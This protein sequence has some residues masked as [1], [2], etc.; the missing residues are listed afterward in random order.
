MINGSPAVSNIRLS[1]NFLLIVPLG[2]LVVDVQSPSLSWFPLGTCLGRA[3][4]HKKAPLIRVR[5]TGAR[6][7]S[8]T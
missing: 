5:R 6:S 4:G 3:M 8:Q 1:L 2:M 7:S